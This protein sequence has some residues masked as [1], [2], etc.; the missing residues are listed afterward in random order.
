MKE[1]E[2][3]CETLPIYWSSERENESVI[4]VNLDGLQYGQR[5]SV[6]DLRERMAQMEGIMGHSRRL[7]GQSMRAKYVWTEEEL[8][9][10]KGGRPSGLLGAVLDEGSIVIDI[11]GKV[12]WETPNESAVANLKLMVT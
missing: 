10:Y 2:G 8:Y 3:G 1:Q 12:I 6:S 11:Y 4:V 7:D 5:L 9:F